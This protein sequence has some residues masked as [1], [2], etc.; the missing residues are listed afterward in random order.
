MLT[1][2]RL[3][4][5]TNNLL[6]HKMQS[7]SPPAIESVSSTRPFTIYLADIVYVLSYFNSFSLSTK[8]YSLWTITYFYCQTILFLHSHIQKNKI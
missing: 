1:Q 5:I 6:Y 4:R 7:T 2:S 8:F 3:P